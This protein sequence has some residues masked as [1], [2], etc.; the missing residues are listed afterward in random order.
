M[1]LT[2]FFYTESLILTFGL[3]KS[4]YLRIK[5]PGY[6]RPNFTCLKASHFT[7]NNCWDMCLEKWLCKREKREATQMFNLRKLVKYSKILLLN[8]MLY[9]HWKC[10]RGIVKSVGKV[11]IVQWR[12]MER[13]KL[14]NSIYVI[15]KFFLSSYIV[16]N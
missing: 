4:L 3:C 10:Y 2:V 9:S 12:K 15:T 6:F 8:V 7:K 13:N 14:L 1:W 16:N 5:A 11:H